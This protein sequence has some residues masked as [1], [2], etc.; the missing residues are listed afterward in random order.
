MII[1]VSKIIRKTT[2]RANFMLCNPKNIGDHI[3]FNANCTIKIV[4]GISFSLLNPSFKNKNKD[5]AI[6]I[7]KIGHT[8]AKT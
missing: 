7:Y 3:K 8:I 4:N 5:T 6:R 2:T 1:A